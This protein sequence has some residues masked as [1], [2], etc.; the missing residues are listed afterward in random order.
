[1]AT[2]RQGPDAVLASTD[3][4]GGVT[5][6][7]D[8]PDTPDGLWMVASNN[9][10]QTEVRTSFPTPSADPT[11]GA[12]LQEFKTWTRQFDETQAGTPDA[13]IE[14]WENGVLVRAGANT[15]VPDGGLLLAFTWNANELS[16]ADGSLVECKV[17][18][19]KAGGSPSSRNTVDVG[20]VEWNVTFVG[21]SITLG[22]VSNGVAVVSG[23]VVVGFSLAGLVLG[24]AATGGEIVNALSFTGL[25]LGVA[26][27]SGAIAN[28]LKLDGL[29]SGIALASGTIN[30]PISLAGLTFGLATV[31]GTLSTTIELGGSVVGAAS[32]S[33]AF[34][35]ALGLAALSSGAVS[36]SGKIV[37]DQILAT[38]STG[39]TT[40]SGALSVEVGVG[41][42]GRHIWQIM[43]GFW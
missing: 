35:T 19:V 26:T 5:D 40:V 34:V 15:A 24:A 12:D 3:L 2:E 27:P 43:G 31:N 10:V 6:I 18:G 30:T 23:N 41:T 11:V 4:S 16:T 28:A 8:D 42:T 21:P 22:G 25:S 7:D 1:M 14:L 32:V 17:V 37:L 29:V 13:R 33:G 38:T 9:N 20:A 36:V 39:V